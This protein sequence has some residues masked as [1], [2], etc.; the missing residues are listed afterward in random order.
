MDPIWIII[1]FGL[2]WTVQQA[3]LP[4]LLG[5][6]AAGFVLG[7][8]GVNGG[9]F[10]AKAAALGVWLLL[11]S[12]GLKLKLGQLK[13]PEVLVVA[14]AHLGFTVVLGAGV[15]LGLGAL[16]VPFLTDLD[17]RTA[18]LL[19]FALA[20]S[21]TVLAVKALEERGEVSALHGRVAIGILIIQDIAAVLFLAATKG[22]FPSA[23]SLLL[24]GALLLGRPLFYRLLDL[25]G[26]GEL[27][28]LLGLSLAVGAGV[29]GFQAVGLKA[30]LGV[31]FMGVLMS[32]HRRAEELGRSLFNL[33]DL[34][35][36]GFFL[37]IGMSGTPTL[38]LAG[39]GVALALFAPIK[40]LVFFL[41]LT[42]LKLRPRTSLLASLSL[43]STSEF[44]LLVTAVAAR[45]GWLRAE[46]V[47]VTTVCV[48][49]TFVVA[50]PINSAA[51]SLYRRFRHRLR[52]FE[53]DERLAEERPIDVS[54]ANILICGMGMVGIGAYDAM[55]ERYGQQVKGIDFD[56][57]TVAE[58]VAQG[59]DVFVGDATD[60][61]LWE[62]LDVSNVSMI[63]LSIPNHAE[64]LVAA[65][66][67]ASVSFRGVLAG[68]A[69]YESEMEE[70]RTAGVKAAFNFFSEAGKGFAEHVCVTASTELSC[71]PRD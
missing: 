20:F 21:S 17:S 54:D 56:A 41:F 35:L 26:R 59:R 66:Q 2:G 25:A 38:A 19:A 58:Q 50:S 11:F 9:V 5:F 39:L 7:S 1:A 63:M 44:G 46:W 3:R 36:V 48:A 18:L 52:F 32:R 30:E 60:I 65:E 51:P 55:R 28:M 57:E 4:P 37:Q 29:A 69:L 23:W 71:R 27:V 14:T 49:A 8:C 43:G 53:T 34:L 6:L 40:A 42:R 67:L 22:A 70:L 12:I 45:A 16:G 33:K 31:L 24:V 68:T 47:V 13:R 10:L 64:N 61:D 62:R 15:F